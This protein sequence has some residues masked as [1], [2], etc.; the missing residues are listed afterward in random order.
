[1]AMEKFH[2]FVIPFIIIIL[3]LIF[4]SAFLSGSETAFIGLNRIRLRNLISKGNDKAKI[5]GGLMQNMDKLITTILIS[6]N[7]VN[8]SISSIVTA[9]FIF[10][11]GPRFGV[12][13][14]T[15]IT[16]V[17]IL[18][19]GEITP[20]I[21]ASSR[22]EKVSLAVGGILKEMVK[23]MSPLSNLFSTVSKKIITLFGGQPTKRSP[24]ITEEEIK[25]M[26]E[27]GREEGILLEKEKEMLHRIFKFGDTKVF[28]VM[29]PKEKISGID[30]NS[31]MDDLL[32]LTIKENYSRMP[33]Y[34][35]I[36]DNIVGVV[37]VKDLIRVQK[38]GKVLE[39]KE[40]LHP[41]FIC[42][43]EKRV[44]DLLRDFQRK[45]I[46][47]SIVIREGQTKGIV[48]LEDLLEEIVGEIEDEYED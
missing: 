6:N 31:S 10:Y 28:E 17:V 16:T 18:I 39:I 19:F 25:L 4:L 8:V 15:V 14:A 32:K 36:L 30:V 43:P 27:I 48:T 45:H 11:F 41:A 24:L 34:D 44:I 5:V 35:K 37:Y 47:M 33:V 9:I 20:K 3:F 12:V 23:F 7:F 1:M 13:L 26:I 22:S 2:I 21:F 40:L 38:E 46:H 42:D 29:I